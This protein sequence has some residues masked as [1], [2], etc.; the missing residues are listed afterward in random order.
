M[1]YAEVPTTPMYWDGTRWL[2]YDGTDWVDATPGPGTTIPAELV[3]VRGI[4][5]DADGTLVARGFQQVGSV[6]GGM[7][8]E[9]VPGTLRL[10]TTATGGRLQF[11]LNTGQVVFDGPLASFHSVDVA[12][13]DSSLDLWQGEN[14]YRICMVPTGAAGVVATASAHDTEALHWRDYLQN[15][16]AMP[17]A[18]LVVKKPM[19]A[20]R[21]MLVVTGL[22][23]A[24][25]VV[26]A[27]LLF[28]GRN[29]RY[30][31]VLIVAL[32]GFALVQRLRKRSRKR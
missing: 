21:Q 14:R 12:W 29:F 5:L 3:G 30:V 25:V 11:A 27:G 18:G 31:M 32:L 10:S 6:A 7:M 24:L 20:K 13:W 2:R 26:P 17:P 16:V 19:G 4:G 22:L 15:R 23:V 9:P 1:E 28:A 8:S